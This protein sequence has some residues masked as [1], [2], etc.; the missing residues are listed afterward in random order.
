[1]GDIENEL[2]LTGA[3]SPEETARSYMQEYGSFDPEAAPG[4][5]RRRRTF[6][7]V[8]ALVVVGVVGAAIITLYPV[9]TKGTGPSAQGP[10]LPVATPSAT[11]GGSGSGTGSGTGTGDPAGTDASSTTTTVAAT[12][13]DSTAASGAAVTPNVVTCGFRLISYT[14][15]GRIRTAIPGFSYT[16][17]EVV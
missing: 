17:T 5:V 10:N 4:V 12:T 1:M 2:R 3:L 14:R 8:G 13:T 9:S 6:R 16:P 7:L 11:G 15:S